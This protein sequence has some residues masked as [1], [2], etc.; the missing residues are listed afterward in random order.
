MCI[1]DR[2]HIQQLYRFAEGVISTDYEPEDWA[3]LRRY[4]EASNLTHR[5]EILA[6]IASDME[7]D[8]KEA[9]IR[10]TYPEEYRFLLQNCYPAL[11][12]TD[13][14]IDYTIR[15]FSDV[16]EIRRLIRTQPQKLS[17][18]EFFL[19]ARNCDPGSEEFVS[20]FET[21]AHMYPD[22]PTANLNA[23]NAALG[24]GDLKRAE[25]Y[26][27]KSGSSPE[28]V[29]ARGVLAVLNGDRESARRLFDQAA[30][31]GIAEAERALRQ[32]DATMR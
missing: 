11:R 3:G 26:L 15:S 30:R 2:N 29:Y 10:R 31:A 27:S 21:A 14:R 12:H 20:I 28:A 16:E 5:E 24:R 7:P 19:A 1:R 32:L 6:L 17:L 23:A 25:G 22:D 13:Y 4:V 18:N 9:K 8:A